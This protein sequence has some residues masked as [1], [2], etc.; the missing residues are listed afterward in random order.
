MAISNQNALTRGFGGK[1]GDQ[2]ILRSSGG[3]SIMSALHD[4]SRKVW[5]PAQ[6]EGR[7]RFKLAVRWAKEQLRDEKKRRYYQK[8]AKRGQTATNVAIADYMKN[9][10]VK[11]VDFVDTRGTGE[12][13]RL[14]LKNPAGAAK[15]RVYVVGSSGVIINSGYACNQDHGSCWSYKPDKRISLQNARQLIIEMVN[16]PVSFSEFHHLPVQFPIRS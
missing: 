12:E 13:I 6:V 15:I 14:M 7:N 8:K 16:G 2:F 11:K 1:F 10:R 9:L 3:R 4:Y 5:S